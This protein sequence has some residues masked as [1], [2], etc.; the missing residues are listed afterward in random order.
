[1]FPGTTTKVS[2]VTV[3]SAAT[4]DVKTDVIFLTGTTAIATLKPNFGGGFSGVCIIVP[5]GG[6]TATLTTGNIAAVVTMTDLQP[7][8]FVFNKTTSKWYPGAIS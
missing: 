3:A 6:A 4:L 5:T 1:M 2:Q 7:C 8:L